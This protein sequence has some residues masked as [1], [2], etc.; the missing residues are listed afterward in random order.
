LDRSFLGGER[1]ALDDV[2]TY[3]AVSVGVPTNGRAGV[4]MRVRAVSDVRPA[5]LS[6]V[7]ML[8]DQVRGAAG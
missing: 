6:H 2:S 7:T 5:C 1:V 8:L 3:N 4:R